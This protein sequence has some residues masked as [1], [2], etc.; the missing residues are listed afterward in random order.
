MNRTELIRKYIEFFKGKDHLEIPGAS[1]IPE[2]D[3][4]VLFTTA[5]MHPLVP[6]LTGQK[7]PLGKRLVDVQRCIRTGDIE[8][9]GDTT[10]HTFFEMLG[11]WSL[12]DY[13]KEEAIEY[14]FEFLTKILKIPK[15]RLAVSVFAG[16]NDAPRDELS[17]K[18]WE[19]LGI[20][21]KRIAY[22]PK[23]NNWWGPAGETG[24]C[25]PD[26]EMFYWKINSKK[27]PERFNPE[28]E[29]WVEI[30]NDVLMQY[31]K[32]K[33]GRYNEAEQKNIDTGMGVER[34]VAVLSGLEDNYLAD[35]WKPIIERIE[36]LSGKEYVENEKTMRIIADHIKAA[37]FMISDGV[38]PSNTERGY[39]LR[40]IIRRAIRYG[41]KLELKEF[42]SKIAE[43][44]FRIYSD[45]K[46]AE[47]RVLEEL[48]EEEK[49]FNET[50]ENGIN[51]FNK[52]TK[53]KK[54]LSGKDGFLLYQ[55][56]GFPLE[57]IVEEAK[58]KKI[59]FDP[60]DFEAEYE[61][62]QELSRSLSAG[63]FKSGL[64][65]NSAE[66][67]RLHTATHLLNE[68]LRQVLGDK[69]IAQRGSNITPE[70]LRFDFNFGRRL[71]DEEIKKIE[72]WVNDKIKKD[73]SVRR[74]EMGLEEAMKSE[75]QHE[76]GA[77]YPKKV[78]VYTVY[79]EKDPEH[80]V[81]RE[82]C[83]GPHVKKTSEI[84][85]FR[86]TKEESSSAGI[87]RIK[88]VVE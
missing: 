50:L 86:I 51:I 66:T 39:V 70:R 78:S 61:K 80:F 4:T 68:A 35:M 30:W 12:G 16:D 7:H 26:T 1:L 84:G 56:Y 19:R 33:N 58:D 37:V 65:D 82:I 25:G 57:M 88:A 24:P 64:I 76:F 6:F 71:T 46:I 45:Y 29:N 13:F 85:R 48:E 55:S 23:K 17:A 49:K 59:R 72:D 14:S 60:K 79:D 18:E 9:V 11:N 28:D 43:P 69:T 53:D 75:A 27:A 62:H 67:T 77:K 44:V 31:H 15:E 32:D 73:L 63:K 81:S 52:L 21:K 83:T 87:R 20:P 42:T 36:K 74:E 22:L 2:N 41:K 8:D 10:H 34:T 54:E 47:K 5:G 40:R 38:S 3:P